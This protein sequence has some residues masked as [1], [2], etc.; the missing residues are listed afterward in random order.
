MKNSTLS[1]LCG[2]VLCLPL[3]ALGQKKPSDI[4]IEEFFKPAQYSQMILSPDGTKLAALTPYKGRDNLVVIDLETNK[5]SI[6]TAFENGDAS[7]IFW[8]NSKRI[9]LRVIDSKVV[10]GEPNFRDMYCINADGENM[11]NLTAYANSASQRRIVPLSSTFDGSDDY[12]MQSWERSRDSADLYR[13]NTSTGRHDLLTND[14]PGDVSKWVIDRNLVPRVA[15]SVPKREGKGKER[16]ATVWHR[17]S[18]D[19][20]WE[21][22]W[23]YKIG[24]SYEGEYDP[25]AFDFDNETLYVSSNVGRDKAAIYP[26][27]T[28]TRKMGEVILE[29]PLIDV[30]RGLLFSRARKKLVGVRLEADK[31]I[32]VWLDADMK[33]IQTSIDAA[34]PKTHNVLSAAVAKESLVL[35]AAYSDVDSGQ[36]FLY[37]D[38]KKALEPI[39]KRRSWLDPSLMAER[40]FITY[41]ARD[42]MEIPAWITIPKGGARNLP[43]V[44]NIHGGPRARVY[45]WA[46]TWGRPEAQFFASRGYVVL[47]PEPRGS[48]GFGRKHLASGDKQWGLAMQD[49]ITDGALHLVKEG[50][51]DKNRMCLHGASYGGYA[52]LQGLVK[53]PEL[54]KCGSAFVAVSDLGLMQTVAYSDTAQLSDYLDEEFTH[55]VGDKERDRALFDQVSPA[56][57]AGKIK[58]KL[59]LAMGSDDV[60]VVLAHGTAMKNAMESAGKP[61]EYVV[62]AGEAHGFNK[63]ENVFDFYKRVEKLMAESLR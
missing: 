40:R 28:K 2:A 60:R 32:G 31:P 29:H 43:L 3:A 54:W 55:W 30:D 9:C 1:A 11:R 36:Y 8:V 59:L 25:V 26:Y 44:V 62:Y 27:N 53:D 23:S 12:I 19:A 42:G 48:T 47:E 63:S 46:S 51:V 52:T 41:K 57:N 58:A 21:K 20:K 61:I 33:R 15:V 16:V 45:S 34:L 14:S 17:A 49:D 24:W 39:A 6:I 37:D 5:P 50:L 10:S 7:A 18:M 13:F 22:L 4:T 35:V 56:R 38:A